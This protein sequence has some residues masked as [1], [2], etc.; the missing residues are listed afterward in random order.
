M[1]G[2]RNQMNGKLTGDWAK[3]AQEFF[4]EG[5]STGFWNMKTID[6]RTKELVK[7][8]DPSSATAI[9]EKAKTALNFVDEV[10]RIVE[11]GVRLSAYHHLTREKGWTKQ[12]A[13]AYVKDMT[14]NFNRHG[15]KGN[16]MSQ[17]YVFFNA[18]VQGTARLGG[19]LFS[20]DKKIRK[21]A[22]GQAALMF[23]L[24]G[25]FQELMRQ[26]MGKDDD[27]EYIYD[28]VNPW[29]RN[30]KIVIPN[31][32]TDDAKDYFTIPLPY[33]LSFL[34][35]AGGSLGDIAHGNFNVGS[36]MNLAGSGIDAFSPYGAAESHTKAGSILKTFTP[37]LARP[38]MEIAL[39]EDFAGKP[40][41]PEQNP[42]SAYQKPESEMYFN[43]IN[44]VFK[45]VADG[46]N[47]L[48]GGDSIHS[49]KVSISPEYLE[50]LTT[51]YT[52][53]VGRFLVGTINTASQ[54]IDPEA[55]FEL[56]RAPFARVFAGKVSNTADKTLFKKNEANYE[57]AQKELREY[58]DAGDTY[59]QR[60][61]E[62]RNK[63]LL[64]LKT[65]YKKIHKRISEINKDERDE[66][67]PA[68]IR[69][70]EEEKVTEMKKFNRQ[71]KYAVEMLK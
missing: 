15:E 14:I 61:A 6:S 46:L 28:K 67:S 25:L 2:L 36:A 39:N 7:A 65:D 5:A 32:L 17:L 23:G 4:D 19:V 69:H 71:Y 53:G 34:W 35:A 49:G 21:A 42:F 57:A 3:A 16:I 60:D 27:D 1:N 22:L 64:D 44:P 62:M 43:S 9:K 55:S 47:R 38:A 59:G 58:E 13:A 66:K 51:Y 11:N 40:I 52:A 31:Y 18:S 24:S 41:V 12:K 20:K 50:Y 63:S 56:G 33:G 68:R 48:T 26:I 29:M 37:T 30:H 8:F 10:N 54:A 45:S 70:L